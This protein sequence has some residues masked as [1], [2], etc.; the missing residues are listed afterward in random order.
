MDS[1]LGREV[2]DIARLRDAGA[3]GRL[4]RIIGSRS[5]TL[6]NV[7]ALAQDLGVDHKTVDRHLRILEDL[8]LVRLH[9]AWRPSLSARE[10]KRPKV[11]LIDTGMLASLLGVDV[12]GIMSNDDLAR[13]A[14]ETFVTMELVKLASWS[15]TAPRLLHFRDRDRHEVDIV[16]EHANADIVGIEVKSSA[17]VGPGDFRSLV[18]LRDRAPTQ[19]PA[20]VVMHAGAATVPF[21]DRLWALPISALWTRP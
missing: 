4:L 15:Q 10:V 5:A 17:T 1:I 18:H 9:P 16:M 2:S 7:N 20:G 12:A 14:F 13:R 11:F 6:L 8:M 21:S 3:V 19:F